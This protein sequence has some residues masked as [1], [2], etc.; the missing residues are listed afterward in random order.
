[1]VKKQT[2]LDPE[3]ENYEI[4]ILRRK[5]FFYLRIEEL[6]IIVK[7]V[8][9]EKGIEKLKYKFSRILKLYYETDN[10]QKLPKPK[11]T[12]RRNRILNELK[13]FS[14]KFLIVGVVILFLT[15]IGSTFIS[16]KAR[17]VSVV[18]I[19]KSETRKTIS[20]LNSLIPDNETEKEK[21]LKK[22][23]ALISELKPYFNELNSIK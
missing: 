6:N 12:I 1:M 2:I 14:L 18:D 17:Q 8:N 13:I 21:Q 19:L 5:N 7:D 15:L 4:I 22:F 10:V 16:M 9:I 23:K 11:K 20:T 3:F